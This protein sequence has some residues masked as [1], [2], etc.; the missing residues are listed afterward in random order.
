MNVKQISVFLDNRP[1]TILEMSKLFA[2][3][4]VNVK[5]MTVMDANDFTVVRLIVDNVIVSSA[6]WRLHHED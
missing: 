1:G 6:R 5:A 4:Q 3:K 2:Q